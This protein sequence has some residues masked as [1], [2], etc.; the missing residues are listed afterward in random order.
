MEFFRDKDGEEVEF[1][2]T[3]MA[4][5]AR[6]IDWDNVECVAAAAGAG[7]LSKAVTAIILAVI[8]LSLCLQGSFIPLLFFGTTF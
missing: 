3:V 8:P 2:T 4:S 1:G 7:F 5:V 6:Q